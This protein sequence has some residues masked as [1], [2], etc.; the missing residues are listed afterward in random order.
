MSVWRLVDIMKLTKKKLKYLNDLIKLLEGL[1]KPS[2]RANFDFRGL[3]IRFDQQHPHFYL[4]NAQGHSI[5]IVNE[6]LYKE[7]I[8]KA[9]SN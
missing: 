1:K 3:E 2:R 8:K 6:G 4:K 9:P 5:S 7:A